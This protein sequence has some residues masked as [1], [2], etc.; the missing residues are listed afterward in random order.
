MNL[1]KLRGKI[2][3]LEMEVS[4]LQQDLEYIELDLVYLN[5][6]CEELQYNLEFLKKNSITVTLDSYSLSLDQ[7]K[8]ARERILELKTLKR[9]LMQSLEST[10]E[11]QLKYI[12]IFMELKK[13]PQQAKILQFKK[14]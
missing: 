12:D 1:N 6:I 14:D 13:Q 3:G 10:I 2:I 8:A 4:I 5:K 9:Q 11:E 7:L